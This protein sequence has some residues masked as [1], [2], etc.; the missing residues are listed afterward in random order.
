MLRFD[1]V[2]DGGNRMVAYRE[3]GS[4]EVVIEWDSDEYAASVR[5]PE[6]CVAALLFALERE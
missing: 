4:G 6:E 2:D 3:S 1:Y 5:L